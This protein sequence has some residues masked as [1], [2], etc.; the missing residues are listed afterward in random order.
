MKPI[1]TALPKLNTS[2][3]KD[4][5][6][7]KWR[8]GNIV[9]RIPGFEL[10]PLFFEFGPVANNFALPGRPGSNTTTS[11]ARFEISFRLAFR[12]FS[13]LAG[14]ANLTF[15]IRPVENQGSLW[16]LSQFLPF[17]AVVIRKKNEPSLV[18]AFKENNSGG[19]PAIFVS[20]RERHR[21][22]IRY[23]RSE[24]R[25][26]RFVD[27]DA[28]FADP[29]AGASPCGLFEPSIELMDWIGFEIG[30]AKTCQVIFFAE[31]GNRHRSRRNLGPTAASTSLK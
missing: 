12:Q 27:V 8:L 10:I 29:S 28:K 17:T 15:E 30:P 25:Q 4:I 3:G 14:N 31:V 5:A 16:I 11:R 21:V 23:F 20:G 18:D 6:A 9:A 22:D 2:R 26:Q 24:E 1:R 19:W 7:P 13:N